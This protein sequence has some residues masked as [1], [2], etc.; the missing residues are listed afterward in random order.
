V[1]CCVLLF[2]LY[3]LRYKK[4]GKRCAIGHLQ[5]VAYILLRHT[6]AD[7]EPL[8]PLAACQW[9]PVPANNALVRT[10]RPVPDKRPVQSLLRAART[11]F[12]AVWC[13][14]ANFSISKKYRLPWA[15]P[16]WGV[17]GCAG[18]CGDVE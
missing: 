8:W 17:V 11:F 5:S 12:I 2:S 10:G 16:V 7:A 3:S 6:S 13:R 1:A 14:R 15:V 9:L 4:N 18:V